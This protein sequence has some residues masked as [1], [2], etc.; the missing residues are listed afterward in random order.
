M[1]DIYQVTIRSKTTEEELTREY[2]MDYLN[3]MNNVLA[4][5][6]E[7]LQEAREEKF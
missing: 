2:D 6:W 4:Q 7:A 3:R 1:S 5:M